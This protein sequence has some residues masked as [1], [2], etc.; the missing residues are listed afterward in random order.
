M[1]LITWKTSYSVGVDTL[2]SDHVI[3]TS[4]INHI[5]D[6]K[7]SGRDEQA[8]SMI[9]RALIEYALRHF[10]REEAMMRQSG[11]ADLAAHIEEHQLLQDQLTEM[12]E[13]YRRTPDPNIS[14][15]IME[16]LNFWI[17]DHILKVDMG[18]KGHI[19][20]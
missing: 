2:D 3:L 12:Y 7:L 15:E 18:Y 11:Y 8:I 20:R 14:R 6:A 16:L 13:E 10:R 5:D 19:R 1:A 4:L 9:L 17:V